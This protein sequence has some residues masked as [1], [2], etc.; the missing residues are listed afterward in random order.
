[1]TRVESEL[2]LPRV[3]LSPDGSYSNPIIIDVEENMKSQKTITEI[4]QTS[5]N[6]FKSN[7]T[8]SL[9]FRKTQLR[10]L[11]KFLDDHEADIIQA[12]YEDI[13]KHKQEVYMGELNLVRTDLS[14][15]LFELQKWMK[16]QKPDK[17]LIN[18]LDGVYL[19]NDP[20]GVVLIIG[21]WNFPLMLLIGPLI[22]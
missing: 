8:K 10:S 22:G 21:A 12:I 9:H 6:F 14:H 4:I 18:V 7:K 20:Y 3:K 2:I 15:T 16:P 17:R 1:M 13:K 5:R 19:Y 11:E